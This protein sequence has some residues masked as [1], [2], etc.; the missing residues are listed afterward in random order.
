M[1]LFSQDDMEIL[2]EDNEI[3]Y[4]QQWAFKSIEDIKVWDNTCLMTYRQCPRLFYWSIL[5]GF[6]PRRKSAALSFGT[7]W[8]EF[9]EKY[10]LD[11]SDIEGALNFAAK[12]FI[13][14]GQ[15]DK[16]RNLTSL[17]LFAQMYHERF[18]DSG[19]KVLG[20]EVFGTTIIGDFLYGAKL[21]GIIEQTTGIFAVEHKTASRMG[22]NF[23]DGWRLA[24]QTRG[25]FHVLKEQIEDAKG[26]IMNVAHTVTKPDFFREELRWSPEQ[27]KDWVM[28]QL[29][30]HLDLQKSQASNVWPQHTSSCMTCYGPCAFQEICL[31]RGDYHEVVPSHASYVPRKWEPFHDQTDKGGEKE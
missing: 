27:D 26:I 5:R 22:A 11:P 4:S 13:A 9:L 12:N 14:S 16:T 30:T 8:H 1:A 10:L 24:T 17:A 2:T 15:Q 3:D 20:T 31:E 6:E 7:A 23:F 19:W 29:S 25:Y 18:A 21:D 28:T